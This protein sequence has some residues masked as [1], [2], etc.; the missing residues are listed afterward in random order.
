MASTEA[1]RLFVKILEV[2]SYLTVAY[3]VNVTRI[4]IILA[5]FQEEEPTWYSRVPQVAEEP[6]VDV[7][8]FV[9]TLMK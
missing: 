6:S 2:C 9:S 7:E 3:V 5:F 8:M 1:M 4:F